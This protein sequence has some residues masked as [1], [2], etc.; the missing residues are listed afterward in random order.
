MVKKQN[1]DH[2]VMNSLFLAFGILVFHVM[3]LVG[4]GVVVLFLHGIVNYM[5]WIL[6]GAAAL[7]GGSVF[8]FLRFMKQGG[9]RALQQIL[10]LPELYGKTIEISLLGGIA[11]FKISHESRNRASLEHP[12]IPSSRLIE[13]PQAAYLKEIAEL[14]RML[15]KNLITPEEYFH[16]K[17]VLQKNE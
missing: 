1:E 2:Q 15:E 4:L 9:A 13:D 17:K 10:S 12:V 7:A 6:L 11:S 3:L 8:L 14:A 5:V 16:A